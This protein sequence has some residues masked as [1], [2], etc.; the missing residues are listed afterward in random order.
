MVR[1]GLD[2]AV[3]ETG[4]GNRALLDEELGVNLAGKTGTAEYCD[5]IALKAGRCDVD[6]GDVLPTHAW[7]MAYGPF[8]AP[9]IVVCAIIENAGHGSEVAAPA[10]RHI[11]KTYLDKHGLIEKDM[12]V[13]EAF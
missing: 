4:T 3:S 1:E 11:L 13:L 5:D 12:A 8:E 7:F 10:V 9:E 6:E 2:I